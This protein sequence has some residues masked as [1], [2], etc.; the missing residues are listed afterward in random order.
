MT[1]VLSPAGDP[2]WLAMGYAEVRQILGDARFGRRHPTPETAAKV[3]Q[4]AV[5]GGPR[6][7]Y[8][9]ETRDHQRRFPGLRLAAGLDELEIQ[10]HRVT[11]GVDRVAVLW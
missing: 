2:A 8:N 1:R 10:S 6:G 3:S 4:A 11:G 7:D 9:T 5:A